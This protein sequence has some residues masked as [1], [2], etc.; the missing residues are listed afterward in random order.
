MPNY[1]QRLSRAWEPT[2][3]QEAT[4][5]QRTMTEEEWEAAEEAMQDAYDKA[6]DEMYAEDALRE[7][8][9]AAPPIDCVEPADWHDVPW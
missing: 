9:E 4:P 3:E 2:H 1:I 7:L 5:E 8:A 6:L